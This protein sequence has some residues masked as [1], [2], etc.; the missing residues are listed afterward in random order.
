MHNSATAPM[1]AKEAVTNTRQG[2]LEEAH[3]QK[4]LLF[5]RP[6]TGEIIAVPE[7]EGPRLRSHYMKWSALMADYHAANAALMACDIRRMALAQAD[8]T[9]KFVDPQIQEEVQRNWEWAI[10][11]RDEAHAK[12]REELKPLDKIGTSGKQLVELIPLMEKEGDN[13]YQLTIE[14]DGPELDGTDLK[15]SWGIKGGVGLRDKFNAFSDPKNPAQLPEKLVYVRSDQLKPA[16]PKFKDAQSVKWSEVYQKGPGGQRKLDQTKLKRYVTE[17]VKKVKIESKDFIKLEAEKCGTL[18]SEWAEQWNKTANWRQEGKLVAGPLTGDIDLSAEAAL[19]RYLMGGS[20]NATFDPFKAGV[21]FKAEGGAEVALAEGKAGASLY[22][23]SMDGWM[24][25]LMDL[26]RARYDLGAI[27]VGASCE[28][29]GAVGASLAGELSLGVEMKDVEITDANGKKL[30]AKAP[31]IYG[32]PAPKGSRRARAVEVSGTEPVNVGGVDAGLNV[33]AGAKANA[34]LKGALQWRNPETRD[35]AFE[36]FASVAPSVGGMAGL[37]GKTKLQVQYVDG[38][39]RIVADAGICLGIGPQGKIEFAVGAKQI[40]QFMMWF[41]YQLYHVN[42]SNLK[43]IGETAFNA[44]RDIAFLA[45]EAEE[46][47]QKFIGQIEEDINDFVAAASIRYKKAEARQALAGRILRDPWALKYSTPETKGML[48][49][50]L[51]RF[52]KEDWATTGFKLG[53]DYLA[54]QRLAILR[55]LR[56][57]QTKADADNILQHI[58]SRGTKGNLKANKQNLVAFFAAEGPRGMDIPGTNAT[59]DEQFD[60][61]YRGL[62]NPKDRIALSGDFEGWYG[63]FYEELKDVPTR[64]LAIARND[65][66]EYA[67]QVAL[68]GRDHSLFASTGDRAFYG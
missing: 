65:S 62:V 22:L 41:Y 39:F 8:A 34:E 67:L 38:V 35:K 64:G 55:V 24:L 12:L 44:A 42:F 47:I 58:H 54:Q 49:Y 56:F 53:Q 10:K 37:G 33:F 3:A 57:A 29:K 36:D 26:E 21:N 28:L 60:R 66:T 68:Q 61:W 30:I 31:H 17:Q 16:W 18:A 9:K 48:I 59:Y 25:Y 1:P 7:I 14:N 43:I 2:S 4:A 20:L 51:S 27:R 46:D 52:G 40:A 45:V 50:Q 6:E 32:R 11:W 63:P 23:P 15:H 19:M 13:P 5:L